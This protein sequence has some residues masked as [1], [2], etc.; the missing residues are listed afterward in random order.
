MTGSSLIYTYTGGNLTGLDRPDPLGD[1]TYV[2]DGLSRVTSRTD[3]K[4]QPTSFEYDALD[5]VTKVTFADGATITYSY[6]ENGNQTGRTLTPS[7]GAPQSSTYG[8]DSLN[9][10]DLGTQ[11]R[12]DRCCA[13][14]DMTASG[15]LRFLTDIGGQVEYRYNAVN[16]LS[17]LGG[18]GRC[19]HDVH[20]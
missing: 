20:V 3:G 7:G 19:E 8:Y 1:E 12:N 15:N 10:L 16:M 4:G 13:V 6:D 11:A 2:V 5:R 9:R 14:R 17:T 18:A